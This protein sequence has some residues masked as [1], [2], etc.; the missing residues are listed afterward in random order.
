MAHVSGATGVALLAQ[1]SLLASPCPR[2]WPGSST[3]DS[4]PSRTEG[5]ALAVHRAPNWSQ[6]LRQPSELV[7]HVTSCQVLARASDQFTG[8]SGAGRRVP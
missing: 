3:Q 1:V 4:H 5:R 8:A 6:E 2:G 7:T